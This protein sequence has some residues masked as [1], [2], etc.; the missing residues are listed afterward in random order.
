MTIELIAP[1]HA[2]VAT[3]SRILSSR[4]RG[5]VTYEDVQQECYVW[6]LGHYS[7]ACKWREELGEVHAER[8]LVKALRNAGERYCRTEKAEVEGYAPDDEF[9]YSIPMVADLLRL[10]YDP[11]WI[12]P[13]SPQTEEDEYVAPARPAS[14][15]LQTMVADV[16]RAVRTLPKHDQQLLLRAYGPGQDT[17]DVVAQLGIEWDITAHAA[18]SRLRRVVGR[19]RAALGGPSPW[20]GDD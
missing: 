19:V 2:A 7:K 13:A 18:D 12:E 10:S 3:A 11:S 20:R 1:D 4:Y 9:F 8:T 17:G 6:L 15:N 16:G 5:F 14:E